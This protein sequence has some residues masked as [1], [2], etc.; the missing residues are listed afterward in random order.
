MTKLQQGES[1][2]TIDAAGKHGV[3]LQGRTRKFHGI[4]DTRNEAEKEAERQR[5]Q[6]EGRN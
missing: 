3:L 4:G 2:H 6:L 5:R 1:K